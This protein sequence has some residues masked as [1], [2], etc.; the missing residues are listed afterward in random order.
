[1]DRWKMVEEVSHKYATGEYSQ[2]TLA[3]MYGVSAGTI[4]RWI[5]KGVVSKEIIRKNRRKF[6]YN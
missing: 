5:N 3:K 2:A 4:S 1:M 6:L